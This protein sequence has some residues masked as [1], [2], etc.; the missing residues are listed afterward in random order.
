MFCIGVLT[1]FTAKWVRSVIFQ[2]IS[3]HHRSKLYRSTMISD[4]PDEDADDEGV[5]DTLLGPDAGKPAEGIVAETIA[6]WPPSDLRGFALGFESETLAWFK[7]NHADWRL[8]MDAVLR[9]WI[10]GKTQSRPDGEPR[11]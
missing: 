5:L 11:G 9:A 10:D 2:A 1:G 6:D 3:A 4:E 8:A 7:A